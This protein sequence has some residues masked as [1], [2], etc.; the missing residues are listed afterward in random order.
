MQNAKLVFNLSRTTSKTN[1]I[2]NPTI[3]NQNISQNDLHTEISN[4]DDKWM[5]LITYLGSKDEP[6]VYCMLNFYQ[7]LGKLHPSR[8]VPLGLVRKLNPLMVIPHHHML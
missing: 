3:A 6:R 4:I 8:L 5:V 7:E 1:L 2:K